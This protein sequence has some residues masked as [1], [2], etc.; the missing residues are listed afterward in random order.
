MGRTWF[1]IAGNGHLHRGRPRRWLPLGKSV[2]YLLTSR[3]EFV[4]HATYGR[5]IHVAERWPR[6]VRL[7]S[8]AGPPLSWEKPNMRKRQA[9]QPGSD[10]RH[11]APLETEYFK[12]LMPLVEHAAMRKYDDGDPREIGWFTVKTLGAAW[13]VQVKD[14]DTATSFTAIGD[15]LDKA[16]DTAALLLAADEAPWEQDGFLAAAKARKKK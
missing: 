3:W 11:L 1:V 15:T 5:G 4:L 6:G 8:L 16:L 2:F 13:C 7:G 14:A 12:E 9:V 10:A